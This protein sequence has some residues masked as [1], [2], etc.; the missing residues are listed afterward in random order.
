[1]KDYAMVAIP[2]LSMTCFELWFIQFLTFIASYLD[3]NEVAAKAII[4]NTT[5]LV[6]MLPL[7][8]QFST[9]SLIGK[10]LSKKDINKAY[11][12]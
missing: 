11:K 12:Y 9:I 3:A 8:I 5:T 6:V 1:M 2:S 7:T 10:A 4:S